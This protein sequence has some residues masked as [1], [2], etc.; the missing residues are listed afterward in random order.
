M[1]EQTQRL[2]SGSGEPRGPFGR[3]QAERPNACSAM[4]ASG[5]QHGTGMADS[6]EPP[7]SNGE[8]PIGTTADLASVCS[9]SSRDCDQ[10]VQPCRQ[11][12]MASLGDTTGQRRQPLHPETQ[13]QAVIPQKPTGPVSTENVLRLLDYQE[14][15]CALTGRPLTPDL[16]SLDHIIPIRVGGEHA[17]ENTQVLHRD[18]NRAK[19]SLTNDEFLQLC[20]EV[21]THALEIRTTATPSQGERHE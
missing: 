7:A 4:A 13:P 6:D 3:R 19:G 2:E 9:E 15:R 16:A 20:S 5:A 8:H 12:R 17:I 21:V 1:Y 11:D 10:G 14:C 18:V